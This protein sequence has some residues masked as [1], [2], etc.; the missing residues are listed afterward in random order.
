MPC[1]AFFP[2]PQNDPYECPLLRLEMLSDDYDDSTQSNQN[3]QIYS[4]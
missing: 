4:S 1:N 2:P 3:N